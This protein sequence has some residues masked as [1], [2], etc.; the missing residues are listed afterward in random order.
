MP[1]LSTP[2]AQAYISAAFKLARHG[3]T[4]AKEA[5]EIIRELT[6][7][8]VMAHE[9][10]YSIDANPSSPFESLLKQE[11]HKIHNQGA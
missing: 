8:D 3:N 1:R 4:F 9:L 2:L 10:F 7:L 5:N 6:A 11:A